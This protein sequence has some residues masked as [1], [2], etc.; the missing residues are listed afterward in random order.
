MLGAT[1]HTCPRCFAYSVCSQPTLAAVLL[2]FSANLEICSQVHRH[3]PPLVYGRSVTDC[4]PE[5]STGIAVVKV[6]RSSS[7]S[8]SGGNGSGGESVYIAAT[9]EQPHTSAQAVPRLQ[10]FAQRFLAADR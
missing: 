5:L 8:G 7:G 6:E 3:H 10:D 9:Y 1:A 4:E 2:A